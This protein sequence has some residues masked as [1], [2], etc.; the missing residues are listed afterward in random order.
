VPTPRF[1]QVLGSAGEIARSMGHAYVGVEH[2][3]LA[4]LRDP[5]AVPTQALMAVADIGEAERRLLAIMSSASYRTPS[6]EV[7]RPPGP[8][9][10][11]DRA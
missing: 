11:N 6:T 8:S 7:H 2:L 9:D 10:D 1:R 5:H 3:F 4:I